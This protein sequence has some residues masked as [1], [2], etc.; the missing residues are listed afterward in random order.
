[1]AKNED[2]AAILERIER[3]LETLPRTTR[4][5]FLLCRIDGLSYDEIAWRLGLDRVP[6]A[7]GVVIEVRVSPDGPELTAYRPTGTARSV[8]ADS[9]AVH[10]S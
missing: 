4:A 6:E 7:D 1:M 10:R 8:V 3:R 9:D 2:E 5:V